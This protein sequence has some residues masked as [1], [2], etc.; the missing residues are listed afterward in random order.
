MAAAIMGAD[1]RPVG[2]VSVSGPH[3]RIRDRFEVL[4]HSVRESAAAI[5]ADL[6]VTTGPHSLGPEEAAGSAAD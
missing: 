6:G 1:G 4:G 5:T 2:A 3:F